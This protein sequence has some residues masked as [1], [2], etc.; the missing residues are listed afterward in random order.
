[1][2][3]PVELSAIPWNDEQHSD[4]ERLKS[5]WLQSANSGHT[6]HTNPRREADPDLGCVD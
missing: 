2:Q 6:H 1:M 5:D 4:V 3:I